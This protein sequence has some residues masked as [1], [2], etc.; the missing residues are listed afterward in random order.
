VATSGDTGGA[1]AA[2]FYGVENVEVVIL[3]PKGKVSKVQEL[4]LTT[5][6]GNVTALEVRG[7]FDDCQALAKQ[8]LADADL[9]LK[10]NLTSANSINIARWLPQ[11][12]Y[13][14]YALKQWTGEPPLLSVPSGNF[15]NLAAGLI[16]HLSGLR[17]NKFIAATNANDVIPRFFA[18]GDYKPRSAVAT[19]ANAMDVG[20]PS[21]FVRVFEI[22]GQNVERLKEKVAATSISDKATSDTIREVHEKY[23]YTLDPHGAVAYRALANH[24]KSDPYQRGIFLETAQPIKF[25]SVTEI[26]GASPETPV[27][28]TELFS[29]KKVSIDI[30]ANYADLKE[31]LISKI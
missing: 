13:Y 24:L 5:L 16:A 4:Q 6:G 11:Q 31:I 3:Y 12:F 14:F 28:V 2:G 18:S 8:A 22:F 17:V 29:R 21:N 25:D 23:G 27:S 19:L 9:H 1:V 30:D 7:T 26:L 15:G 10:A 20:D